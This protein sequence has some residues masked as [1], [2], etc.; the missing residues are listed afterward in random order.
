MLQAGAT[1][2]TEELSTGQELARKAA[3][4]H[5]AKGRKLK[6]QLHSAHQE[7][8]QTTFLLSQVVKKLVSAQQGVTSQRAS[9]VR[10]RMEILKLEAD[11]L[12][13]KEEL[14][15]LELE[16]LRWMGVQ[17]N[18]QL[19]QIALEE[20]RVEKQT[21]AVDILGRLTCHL[22]ETTE[23]G[24]VDVRETIELHTE[25]RLAMDQARSDAQVLADQEGL[26]E[27]RLKLVRD[28]LKQEQAAK[29]KQVK[30]R[31]IARID[32]VARDKT[33]TLSS[34]LRRDRCGQ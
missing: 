15:T 25:G 9:M 23:F 17:N 8:R 22:T 30:D 14:R 28:T 16:E 29:D 6:G 7:V 26:E 10:K 21:I 19:E 13:K 11:C 3:E 12:K 1:S 4:A 2:T 32:A 27:S 33:E 24:C 18:T 5:L 20:T 34:G 31:Q